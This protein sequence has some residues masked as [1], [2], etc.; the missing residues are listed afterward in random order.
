MNNW[1]SWLKIKNIPKKA[2]INDYFNLFNKNGPLPA[3]PLAK[4]CGQSP[5]YFEEE[6]LYFS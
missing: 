5:L 3:F 1:S 4:K 6:S 2:N